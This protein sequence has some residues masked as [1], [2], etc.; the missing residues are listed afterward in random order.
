MISMD[1]RA[2]L[3]VYTN[4]RIRCPFCIRAK[5]IL[6]E[7]SHTFEERDIADPVVLTELLE[8]RPT[9]KTVPQIFLAN[10][11]YI[12]GCEDLITMIDKLDLLIELNT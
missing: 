7:R 11:T 4:S 1:E 2:Q 5:S 10:D 12:G 8:K 3:I 6:T 9:A